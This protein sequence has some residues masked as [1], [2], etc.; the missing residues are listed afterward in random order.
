MRILSLVFDIFFALFW[1]ACG[2]AALAGF[3]VSSFTVGMGLLLA[4]LYNVR[5]ACDDWGRDK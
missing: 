2:I 1:L 5:M 3:E 4:A